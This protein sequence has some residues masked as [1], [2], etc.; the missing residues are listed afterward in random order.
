MKKYEMHHCLDHENSTEVKLLAR[1]KEIF[2]QWYGSLSV[3]EIISNQTLIAEIEAFERLL[4][5]RETLSC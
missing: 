3:K 4:T 2:R 1:L 5:R